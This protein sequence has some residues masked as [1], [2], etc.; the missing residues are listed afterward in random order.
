VDAREFLTDTYGAHNFKALLDELSQPMKDPRREFQ[1]ITYKEGVEKLE[2]VKEKMTFQGRVTNVTNF[3][4]FIDIGVHQDGL[5]HVSQMADRFVR[6]PGEIVAVGDLVNVMVLS[7]DQA[8]K[9]IS[10]KML[11]KK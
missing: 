3:G 5:C 6:D 2:E 1:T 7:V 11:P 10:L 9:R 4:A 8:K